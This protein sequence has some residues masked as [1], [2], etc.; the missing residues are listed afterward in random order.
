MKLKK[1]NKNQIQ[2][3]SVKA[4]IQERAFSPEG[5]YYFNEFMAGAN[6]NIVKSKFFCKELNLKFWASLSKLQ[7]IMVGMRFSDHVKNG[8]IPGVVQ[9]NPGKKGPKKYLKTF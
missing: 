8:K 3:N 9:I 6:L 5:D 1:Q 7:A 4:T 2:T